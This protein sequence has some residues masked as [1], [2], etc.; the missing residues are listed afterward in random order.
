MN[1]MQNLKHSRIYPDLFSY[2]DVDEN[3]RAR[4]DIKVIA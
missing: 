4:S 3:V 2:G 1:H